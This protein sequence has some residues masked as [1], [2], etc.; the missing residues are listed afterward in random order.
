MLSLEAQQLTRQAEQVDPYRLILAMFKDRPIGELRELG[1]LLQKEAGVIA[2]LA[3]YNGPKL[4]A[5][6]SC[7][8]N[9]AVSARELLTKHLAQIGGKGGG[10][11]NIAQGGGPATEQ[12]IETFFN[13]TFDY[14]IESK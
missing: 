2:V 14:I 12:H 1:Q 13:N 9:V 10:D 7:A 4:S 3:G 6:V 5:L 8:D 11:D